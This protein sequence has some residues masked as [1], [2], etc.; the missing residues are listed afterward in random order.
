VNPH[1]NLVDYSFISQFHDMC[2][3]AWWVYLHE[4]FQILILHL[5]GWNVSGLERVGPCHKAQVTGVFVGGI[6]EDD[7]EVAIFSDSYQLLGFFL[8]LFEDF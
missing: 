4:T 3:N 6:V 5:V 1:L 2:I 7:R 8:N